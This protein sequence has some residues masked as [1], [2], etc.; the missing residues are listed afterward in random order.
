MKGQTQA[1][2]AVLITSVVI[3]SVA[4][5]YVWGTPLLEK[6]QSESELNNVE[7]EIVDLYR[8]INRVSDEG[9]GTAEVLTLGESVSNSRNFRISINESE[10]F[11]Q[12]TTNADNPPYALDTWTLIQ[13][14][15]LQ[16]L[17]FGSG[18]FGL[19]GNERPGVIGVKPAGGP[20]SAVMEYRIEF[21]NL[22]AET[23]TS[24]VLEKVNITSQ[25]QS[26]SA[27]EATIRIANQGTV[28][29]EGDERV[30]LPSGEKLR[31][32][33]TNIRISFR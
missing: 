33:N 22:K 23:T 17:S 12:I 26:F 24:T 7:N 18:P 28:W 4:S 11:I 14:K 5:A 3:G 32:K 2:T 27:G 21:R 13:G 16:G 1:V 9:T 25:G 20:G 30:E 29:E 19:K 10:N 6:S 15:S 8:E 31:R